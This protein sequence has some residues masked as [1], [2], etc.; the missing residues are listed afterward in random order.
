MPIVSGNPEYVGLVL[1]SPNMTYPKAVKAA[2]Q[3]VL[4][5]EAGKRATLAPN[6]ASTDAALKAKAAFSGNIYVGNVPRGPML[7]AA[8]MPCAVINTVSTGFCAGTVPAPCAM[9]CAISA[10][11]VTSGGI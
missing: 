4:D 5:S 8:G 2:A 3:K 7:S 11:S 10:G 6:L 9:A 1:V